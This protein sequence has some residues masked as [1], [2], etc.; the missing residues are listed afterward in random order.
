MFSL[1]GDVIGAISQSISDPIAYWVA[2]RF[3][4]QLTPVRRF[5][6][7][8]VVFGLVAV[9]LFVVSVIG[10][11]YASFYVFGWF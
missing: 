5:I 6:L 3:G 11:I 4:W 1:L 9:P 7:Q 8:C 10:L 2:S